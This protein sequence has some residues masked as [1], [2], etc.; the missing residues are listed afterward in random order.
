MKVETLS[1]VAFRGLRD[2]TIPLAGRSLLLL[3]GENGTGKSSVVDALEYL[4]TG[5]VRHLEDSQATSTRKHAPHVELP[6]ASLKV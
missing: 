1:A 6:A 5:E 3:Y 4:A 2:D